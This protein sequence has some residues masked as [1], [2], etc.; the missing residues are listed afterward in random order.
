MGEASYLGRDVVGQPVE[1][2]VQTLS[3]RSACALNVPADTKPLGF[4]FQCAMNSK[5]FWKRGIQT[6]HCLW[7]RE[8]RPSLSVI[9]AAFMAF[10]RSCLLANTRRTAS[11]NSSCNS[12]VSLRVNF[13]SHVIAARITY[14]PCSF[15]PIASSS[16][17]LV[18]HT[19]KLVSCLHHT[20]T[21]VAVDDEDETLGVLE[22]MPPQRTDLDD[23]EENNWLVWKHVLAPRPRIRR[24]TNLI[25]TAD[26][27]HGEANVLVLDSLHVE[28]W[29]RKSPS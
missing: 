10:G 21:I 4:S 23:K 18:Q 13:S 15:V 3:G 5:S 19:V 9:S 24:A 25:L 26:V 29:R 6:Y 7:R 11:R 28:T 16:T 2:L 22:I 14:L 8:W 20:I 17:H 27:P 12:H 1:T